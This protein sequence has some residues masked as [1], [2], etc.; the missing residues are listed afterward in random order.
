MKLPYFSF[1]YSDQ[2]VLL[3]AHL[4]RVEKHL[5]VCKICVKQDRLEDCEIF[6]G[7]REILST[8]FH[9]HHRGINAE[10]RRI[11]AHGPS[12][13][14]HKYAIDIGGTRLS[15]SDQLVRSLFSAIDA[16]HDAYIDALRVCPGRS[17]WI[18]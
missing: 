17:C 3:D 8:L 16:L 13:Y 6:V 5:G 10:E 9:G 2:H 18:A 7:H 12:E 1:R 15:I 11:I 14:F 4:P